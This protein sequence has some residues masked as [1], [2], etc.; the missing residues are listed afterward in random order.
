MLYDRWATSASRGRVYSPARWDATSCPREILMRSFA[1]TLSVCTV[2][3]AT[4]LVACGNNDQGGSS[5]TTTSS[6][7]SGTGGAGGS[8]GSGGGGPLLEGDCDPLVPS[9]CGYPFPS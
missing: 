9:H 5:V 8:G 2:L 7:S 4:T 6:S 1:A 3:L